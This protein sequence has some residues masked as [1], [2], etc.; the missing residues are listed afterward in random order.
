MTTAAVSFLPNSF[1]VGVDEQCSAM[2]LHELAP[3][4]RDKPI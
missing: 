3:S 1:V 2:L 4:N